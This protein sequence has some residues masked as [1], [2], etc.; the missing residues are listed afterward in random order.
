MKL[1]FSH[2]ALKDFDNC[3]LQYYHKRILKDIPNVKGEAATWGERVHKDL[4]LRLTEGRP[5]PEYLSKYEPMMN[6]FLGLD[7]KCEWKVCLNEDLKPTDWMAPDAWI[8]CVLDLYIRMNTT[9]AVV[10]DY[11]TGKQK[12][13]FDQLKL[14]ALMVFAQEPEVD[15]VRSGFIWTQGNKL[16]TET[17]YRA[18][19]NKLWA[20][21]IAKIRRVYRAAES[22]NWPAKPSG[23]CNWCGFKPQCPYAR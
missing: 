21:V 22:G 20:E 1:T 23:L 10:L 5:L 18:D 3:A 9:T 16:D 8:R 15:E 14:C 11:K 7:F 17:Y 2:S 6:K 19:I 4:E 12:D 13:D